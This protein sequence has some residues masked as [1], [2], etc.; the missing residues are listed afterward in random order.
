MR[1]GGPA[2][3]H[4]LRVVG[5]NE[6]VSLRLLLC[7]AGWEH[8][9]GEKNEDSGAHGGAQYGEFLSVPLFCS[10]LTSAQSQGLQINHLA[11]C[12]RWDHSPT[13]QHPLCLTINTASTCPS[14]SLNAELLGVFLKKCFA[15]RLNLGLG[16]VLTR[17]LSRSLGGS[18]DRSRQSE[19]S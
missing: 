8:L 6:P 5:S 15:G 3:A 10:H 1:W 12:L 11:S 17:A 19:I 13:T 14:R 7:K 16:K 4:L 2:H 9:Q 18:K